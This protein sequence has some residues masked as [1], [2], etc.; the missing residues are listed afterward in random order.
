MISICNCNDIQMI[1]IFFSH[2]VVNYGIGGQY[3]AHFD[4]LEVHTIISTYCLI[5]YVYLTHW[6][7]RVA[8]NLLLI[9]KLVS[10]LPLP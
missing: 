3:E 4:Y 2:Q 8:V 7:L 5:F 9:F 6:S 10:R 1:Y